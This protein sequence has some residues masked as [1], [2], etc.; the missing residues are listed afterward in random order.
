MHIY[1]SALHAV[2]QEE[3]YVRLH[4]AG[5]WTKREAG[6]TRGKATIHPVLSS[7]FQSLQTP[8]GP[9]THLLSMA[10]P[11]PSSCMV[12]HSHWAVSLAWAEGRRGLGIPPFTSSSSSLEDQSLESSLPDRERGYTVISGNQVTENVHIHSYK[13]Q[14]S[15]KQRARFITLTG[16]D[17]NY[18]TCSLQWILYYCDFTSVR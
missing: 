17:V 16:S 18:I 11:P 14:H 13:D 9:L 5:L 6:V 8:V 1:S 10:P 2:Q 12:L 4:P 3:N 7:V 15:T